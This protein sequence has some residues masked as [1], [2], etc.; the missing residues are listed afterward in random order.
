M[1]ITSLNPGEIFVFGSNPSGF[2][3]AGAARDAHTHFGAV[4]GQANGLQGQSYGIDTM[5]GFRELKKQVD[6]FIAFAL[7]HPELRFLLSPIGC[8]L[9]GYDARAIA[10]LFANAPDNVVLPEMFNRLIA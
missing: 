1:R 6:V 2:H 4:W 5:S 9:A 8:G 10:P 3:G 7:E